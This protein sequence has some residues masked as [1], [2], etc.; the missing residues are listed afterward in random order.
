MR[1]TFFGA[2][3]GAKAVGKAASARNM[4]AASARAASS[5][6]LATNR[7]HK[8]ATN[9]LSAFGGGGGGGFRKTREPNALE[10]TEALLGELKRQKARRAN[11][12][13]V[14][15]RGLTRHQRKFVARLRQFHASKDQGRR[16]GRKGEWSPE[17]TRRPSLG[18]RFAPKAAAPEGGNIWERKAPPRKSPRGR[19]RRRRRSKPQKE[20]PPPPPPPSNQRAES[21]PAAI[22][23]GTSV[24]TSFGRWT[25]PPVATPLNAV[26][27]D[28]LSKAEKTGENQKKLPLLR[29]CD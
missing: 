1:G 6:K 21:Q 8:M 5:A 2:K 24:A 28:E 7:G 13:G 26:S 12:D 4:A 23:V 14:N 20:K 11:K 17:R 16:H 25:D 22:V 27:K 29:H 19:R 15:V 18:R 10:F 9:A 3:P